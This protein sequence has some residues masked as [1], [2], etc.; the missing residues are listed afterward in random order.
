MK[1]MTISSGLICLSLILTGC[2]R[3]PV[4]PPFAYAGFNNTTA[5]VD[6]TFQ[7][8]SIGDRTGESS[9]RSILGLFSWG[10]ASIEAA[11]RNGNLQQV[12][13]I[14]CEITSVVFGIYQEYT[15][16]VSGR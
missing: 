9:A 15:T 4:I 11:A 7:G 2:M 3:S 6:I 1:R 5:P 10:D 12:E 14:D 8:E 13:Q 16:V